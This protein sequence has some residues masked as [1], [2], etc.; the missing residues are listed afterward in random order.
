MLC[1][2]LNPPDPDP[3]DGVPLLLMLLVGGRFSSVGRGRRADIWIEVGLP[4]CCFGFDSDE[5]KQGDNLERE[6]Q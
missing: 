3:F 4:D 6:L 1:R 2:R 5:V